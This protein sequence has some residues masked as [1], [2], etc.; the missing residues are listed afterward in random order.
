MCLWLLGNSFDEENLGMFVGYCECCGKSLVE[1]DNFI[2]IDG[3]YLICEECAEIE[4]V[5]DCDDGS[6]VRF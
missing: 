1:G 5:E 4:Q 2:K 3:K 6:M